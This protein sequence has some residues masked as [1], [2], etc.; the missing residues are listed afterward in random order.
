MTKEQEELKKNYDTVEANYIIWVREATSAFRLKNGR[1]PKEEEL[2]SFSYNKRTGQNWQET[3]EACRKQLEAAG[4]V[5]ENGKYIVK[6]TPVERP[7]EKK[8]DRAYKDWK[9]RLEKEVKTYLDAS[10]KTKAT[11]S[12][13]QVVKDLNKT[14]DAVVTELKSKSDLNTSECVEVV[15]RL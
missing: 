2:L 1:N 7:D 11:P 14:F 5:L 3:R 12:E 15:Q 13:D 8:V 6:D 10:E 9:K 4:F